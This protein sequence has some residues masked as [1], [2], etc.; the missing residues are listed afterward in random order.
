MPGVWPIAGLLRRD[1]SQIQFSVVGTHQ[2]HP[3]VPGRG[4]TELRLQ[5]RGGT[6][7]LI[8]PLGSTSSEHKATSGHPGLPGSQSHSAHL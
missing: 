3:D 7:P 4:P 1:V 2:G 5:G 6:L 8:S